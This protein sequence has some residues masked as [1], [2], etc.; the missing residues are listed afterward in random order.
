MLFLMELMK[1]TFMISGMH[2]NSCAMMIEQELEDKVNKINVN[3]A[4]EKAEIDFDEKKISEKEIKNE[5]K[6]LGYDIK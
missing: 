4:S 1:K 5:I 6:K 3:F 2:C